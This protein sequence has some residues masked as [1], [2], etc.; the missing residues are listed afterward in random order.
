[1]ATTISSRS[2]NHD[3]AGAK[4]A[5][6]QGPVFITDRGKPAHVLLSIEH[7]HRLIGEQQSIADLLAMP[8]S[9]AIE[10]PLPRHDEL[11]QPATFE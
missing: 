11:P 3:A 8:G 5:A 6:Q 9:E 4:R 1:M 7:Y 10:L 2:F